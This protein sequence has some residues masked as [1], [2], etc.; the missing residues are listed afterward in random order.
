SVVMANVQAFWSR[1]D[2]NLSHERMD[3]KPLPARFGTFMEIHSK[4]PFSIR[5]SLQNSVGYLSVSSVA[6]LH[7]S[8]LGLN[9]SNARH[10][11]DPLV[12]RDRKPFFVSSCVFHGLTVPR[13]QTSVK[14]KTR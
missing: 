10:L 11:V 8:G 2:K 13:T 1:S 12:V 7:S 9:Y 14:S 3:T 4:V 5:V 6:V